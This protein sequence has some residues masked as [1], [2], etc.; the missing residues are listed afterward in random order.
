MDAIE[1]L[2]KDHQ[3]VTRLFQRFSA[4]KGGRSGKAVIDKICND[5]EVHTQIE[6]EIFYPAVREADAE[7]AELVNESL[8][9]HARVKQQVAALKGPGAREEE[10]GLESRVSA[11]EQDV[12]HHVTEEEGQM[13]PRLAEVMDARKRADLGQRMQGRKQQLIGRGA[14]AAGRARAASRKP[15]RVRRAKTATRRRGK[16][17]SAKHRTGKTTKKRARSG[18]GR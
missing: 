17:A 2:K 4:S 16:A 7:L 8:R 14:R 9:E 11:L 10:A 5:L 6:E 13:F 12:E 3:E 18:R 15:S 1:L